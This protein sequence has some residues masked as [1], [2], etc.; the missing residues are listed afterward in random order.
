MKKYKTYLIIA[1]IVLLIPVIYKMTI[2]HHEVSYKVNN[3]NIKETFDIREKNHVYSFIVT[4]GKENYSFVITN[5]INKRKKIIKDIKVFKENKVKCIIPIYKNDRELEIYCLNNNKQVS[6]E[7]LK[8]N[9]DFKKISKKIKKYNITIP[10]TKDSKE[11]YKNITV[12]KSNIPKEYKVLIWNYKG[13]IIF[14]KESTKYQKF[15]DYDLYDN[16]VATTTSRYFVLIENPSVK[17]IE[18]VHCYD[19][20]KN[21]YKIIKLNNEIS[22]DAYIN[23]VVND[24]VYI[25]DRRLEKQYVLDPK[26]EEL[27]EIG[28]EEFSYTLYKNNKKELVERKEFFKED[29]Y[30]KNIRVEDKKI[31][32]SSD[33]VLDYDYYFKENDSFYKQIVGAN[34][35]LLFEKEEVDEWNVYN[36]DILFKSNDELYLYSDKYGLNKLLEY[37]ELNYNDNRIYYIWK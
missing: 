5:K 37:N 12:Y 18:K 16:I 8:N 25:T 26:K 32:K 3:F 20:I 23:G 22:K 29:K 11:E 17:G 7:I 9:E 36:S 6:K 24:L 31:T 14:D 19:L 2:I 13:L 27:T 33:L 15:L 1:V 4:K 34:K 10:K 21:K 28:N 30:F 35:I